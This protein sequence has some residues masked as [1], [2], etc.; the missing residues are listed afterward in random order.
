MKFKKK[1]KLKIPSVNMKI[2]NNN[3]K[4]IQNCQENMKLNY[5]LF[6]NKCF[7]SYL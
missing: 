3:L 4:L 7:K 2:S 1:K 5:Y 6:T